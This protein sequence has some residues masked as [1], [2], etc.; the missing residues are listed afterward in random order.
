MMLLRIKLSGLEYKLW[1][2]RLLKLILLSF[3]RDLISL[4]ML[5][6]SQLI[7][8][9]YWVQWL[10]NSVSQCTTKTDCNARIH[11][12]VMQESPYVS[13]EFV[14]APTVGKNAKLG[15]IARGVLLKVHSYG[16]LKVGQVKIHK[17]R[18]QVINQTTNPGPRI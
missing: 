7:R 4:D 1:S 2:L 3:Q 11:T 14:R 18:R 9:N 5:H 16:E 8:Y 10:C 13:G 6:V 17:N 15:L 12:G